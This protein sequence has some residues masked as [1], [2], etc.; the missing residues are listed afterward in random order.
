[1]IQST[2]VWTRIGEERIVRIC[3]HVKE[4]LFPFS[5]FSIQWNPSLWLHTHTNTH[6]HTH[7]HTHRG[8]RT[9]KVV[10]VHHPTSWYECTILEASFEEVVWYRGKSPVWKVRKAGSSPGSASNWCVTSLPMHVHTENIG[11]RFYTQDRTLWG[12][13]QLILWGPRWQ[14]RLLTYSVRAERGPSRQYSPGSLEDILPVGRS[15][16][17][18]PKAD[19]P[20]GPVAKA[21]PP[22]AG[23]PGLIP[24]PEL[25]S[26][27]LQLRVQPNK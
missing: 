24:G 22:N 21:R 26:R 7:T 15:K 25:R 14:T 19:F 4:Y 6:T 16:S 20:G 13:Q 23:G 2:T 18:C 1:M 5:T 10:H 9:F 17:K 12:K 3:M 11:S 8:T 27:M